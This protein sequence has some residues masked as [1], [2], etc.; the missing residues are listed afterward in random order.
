[1]FSSSQVN[2][3]NVG[4]GHHQDECS[5]PQA[6]RL[7]KG[8]RQQAN[9][10]GHV[11]WQPPSQ[12]FPNVG[13]AWMGAPDFSSSSGFAYSGGCSGAASGAGLGQAELNAMAQYASHVSEGVGE[14]DS[15]VATRLRQAKRAGSYG[16][17]ASS[18]SVGYSNRR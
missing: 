10:N 2:A 9:S 12:P 6:T 5:S 15:P 13:D 18:G 4:L 7:L 17:Q 16:V 8:K 14:L 11:S 1:M 3:G